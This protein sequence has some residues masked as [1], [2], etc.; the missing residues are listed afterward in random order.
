MP[1]YKACYYRC[2]SLWGNMVHRCG[3]PQVRTDQVDAAVWQWVSSMLGDPEA[4]EEGLHETVEGKEAASAPLR[5]RLQI[6]DDLLS[7]N[8]ALTPLMLEGARQFAA[9]IRAKLE[10]AGTFEQRRSLLEELDRGAV[11]SVEDGMKIARA[12]FMSWHADLPIVC[13]AS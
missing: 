7:E 4:L 9:R 11:L 2:G 8:R 13:R 6:N 3:S 1:C 5:A 10:R 12:S